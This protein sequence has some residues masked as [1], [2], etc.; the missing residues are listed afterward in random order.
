[1]LFRIIVIFILAALSFGIVSAQAPAN[2]RLRELDFTPFQDALAALTVARMT[3]IDAL[4][5]NVTVPDIQAAFAAGTLTSEELTVY[6]LARI[7]M[8]DGLLHSYVELNP[9]ALDEARAADQARAEGKATGPLHGI[10]VN[11]KDNIETVAPMHT[12]GGAAILLDHVAEQDAAVVTALRAAGAVIL[13]K[14]NLSELA[15]AI[16]MTPGFS[17]VGGLTVNPYDANT[18]AGG[19]S[20]GSGVSTSAYLTMVSVGTETSGSLIYPAMINGVVGMKP[21]RDLVS[22]AGVIP[23]VRFQDSAGPVGR[24]VT[25]AAVLLN[26]IDTVDVDYVAGLDANA[27]NGVSVGLLHADLLSDV[28]SVVAADEREANIELIV[29]GLQSAGATAVDV[30]LAA[31]PGTFIWVVFGGL[32]NDTM[33]YLASAGAPATTV[34]ELQAYNNAEPEQR[35]PTGQGLLDFAVSTPVNAA[36]YEQFALAFRQMATTA[37]DDAFAAAGAD[38]LVS[39]GN[40]H[41]TYYATAGYPAISIPLG[42]LQTGAPVGVTLI[43]SPGQD[44]ALLSYAY[45]FEQ[46]THLRVNP[47]LD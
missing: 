42:V 36:T 29:N 31:L 14:A 5:V 26:A 44:A 47:K 39:V 40:I 41:S 21:S 9:N 13:G 1:M 19:S 43:G 6:F 15:G 24:T 4:V 33:G 20:S 3:A 45:A 8:Y 17:A 22:G 46:V 18:T 32:Q 28:N 7:Q 34:S 37:L 23:L 12:T 16:S 11:L 25:D 10:P 2:P 30:P 27:L 35:I 38:V